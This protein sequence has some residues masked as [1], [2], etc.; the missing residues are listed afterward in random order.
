MEK[1]IRQGEED[2]DIFQEIKNFQK[3]YDNQENILN[4]SEN[5]YEYKSELYKG[6]I[7]K[8][9]INNSLKDDENLI[10]FTKTLR[11][12]NNNDNEYNNENKINNNRVDNKINI[13]NRKNSNSN[14]N[15]NSNNKLQCS[16]HEHHSIE[17]KISHYDENILDKNRCNFHLPSAPPSYK[18]VGLQFNTSKY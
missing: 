15:S 6:D 17:E 3:K 1:I 5:N 16:N 12:L 8:S 2:V 18:D 11:E 13:L 14:L 10:F 4:L 7:K 9:P